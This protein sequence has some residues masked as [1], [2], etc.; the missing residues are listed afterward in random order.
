LFGSATST[1]SICSA[2]ELGE[3]RLGHGDRHLALRLAGVAHHDLA[4]ADHLA[5]FRSNGGITPSSGATSV[6]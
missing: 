2:R 5:R 6:A 3:L 4:C 1:T